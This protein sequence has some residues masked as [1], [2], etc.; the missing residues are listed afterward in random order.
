MNEKFARAIE[1]ARANR[2]VH[3]LAM[4]AQNTKTGEE[5]SGFVGRFEGQDI[6]PDTP[7]FLASATKLFVTAI[8]MQQ[9]D[10]G[11]LVLS[12]PI[13]TFFAPGRLDGL[14]MLNGVDHTS[15]ITVE[16]LLAHTSGLPDYFEQKQPDGSVFAH[17]ILQGKDKSFTVET[18][19]D[20]VQSGMKPAFAPSTPGRA[21][22][23][24]T[25]YQL[26]TKII[27]KVLGNSF[28]DSVTKNIATPLGLKNTWVFDI[29]GPEQQRKIIPPRNGDMQLDIPLGMTGISGD[30][31]IVSTAA[32]GLVFIKAFFGGEL[33]SATLLDQIIPIAF[34]FNLCVPNFSYQLK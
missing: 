1:N 32:D 30:G 26:L 31:G 28:A 24:D 23:S 16:N 6:G 9:V 7:Y 2:S 12:A 29:E 33:F 4:C 25:N 27:E 11:Q 14:H 15:K 3:E 10:K 21:F 8:I 5:A 19:I 18:V 13:T 22:Y 20:M 17:D 34:D